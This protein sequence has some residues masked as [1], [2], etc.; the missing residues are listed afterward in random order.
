MLVQVVLDELP[1][2]EPRYGLGRRG[3][4]SARSRTGTAR[5]TGWRATP[6]AGTASAAEPARAPGGRSRTVTPASESLDVQHD[7]RDRRGTVPAARPS[8][9]RHRPPA[10]PA[11][12]PGRARRRAARPTAAG[13]TARSGWPP[14]GSAA[15]NVASASRIAD[16]PA[17]PSA[18]ATGTAR[19]RSAAPRPGSGHAPRRARTAGGRS[20][21]RGPHRGTGTRPRPS[22]AAPA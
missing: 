22:A 11:T 17:S 14:A 3:R 2:G 4:A 12:G 5:R 15:S 6:S 10:V 1:G 21:C 9:A 20:G 16:R 19:P 7:C 18:P 13:R 8:P